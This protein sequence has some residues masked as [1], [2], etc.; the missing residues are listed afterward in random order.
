MANEDNNQVIVLEDDKGER[1]NFEV[2]DFFKEQDNDYV[3][4]LPTQEQQEKYPEEADEAVI[5]RVEQ[6]EQGEYMLTTVED[7]DEW[8]RVKTAYEQKME[9]M[10]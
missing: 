6:D 5:M 7:D 8:E 1:H 10:E 4:L 3:V 2:Y 9:E